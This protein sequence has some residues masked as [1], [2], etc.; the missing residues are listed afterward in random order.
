MNLGSS[1]IAPV[2]RHLTWVGVVVHGAFV[3]LFLLLGQ[4]LLAGFNV[5]SVCCWMAAHLVNER[6]RSSLAMWLVVADSSCSTNA[7]AAHSRSASV[8]SSLCS[9]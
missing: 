5:Q 2:I 7:C 3:P 4:P 6:G 9:S 1:R 8:R